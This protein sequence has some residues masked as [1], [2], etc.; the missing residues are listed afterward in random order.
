[1]EESHLESLGHMMLL[2]LLYNLFPLL[3]IENRRGRDVASVEIERTS[4]TH[5][6]INRESKWGLCMYGRMEWMNEWK[7]KQIVVVMMALRELRIDPST[8][9]IYL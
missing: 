4:F 2:L 6:Y 3:V 5:I 7:L 9:A 1:M 8:S